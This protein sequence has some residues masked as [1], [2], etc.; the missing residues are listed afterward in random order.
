MSS[1][2][3]CESCPLKLK[4]TPEN[5]CPKAL[6][7]IYAIQNADK[8]VDHDTLPGCPFAI[9]SSAHNYCFFVLAKTLHGNPIPDKEIC[10]MLQITQ[11]QLD[12]ISKSAI[13]KLKLL[14]GTEIMNDFRDAVAE[15]LKSQNPDHTVYLPSSYISKVDE[16][17]A[18]VEEEEDEDSRL[19][20]DEKMEK[21]KMKKGYGMP[22]HRKQDKV[23]LYGIYSKKTLEKIKNDKEKK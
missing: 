10:S 16:D 17:A 6:E 7:R 14:K 9:N 20:L 2:R 11:K 8:N 1:K 5:E 19:A 12:Q 22:L 15:S 21:K 13:S 3:F 4:D 18:K 23:D